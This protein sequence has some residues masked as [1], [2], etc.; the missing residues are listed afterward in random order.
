MQALESYG[1]FDVLYDTVNPALR[2]ALF[3]RAIL[4]FFNLPLDVKKCCVSELPIHGHTHDVPGMVYE[5]VNMD[6]LTSLEGAERLTRLLWPQGNSFFRLA[7]FELRPII[8]WWLIL[9]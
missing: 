8:D 9:F 2:E 3:S 1:S 7:S 4:E 6:N 5:S